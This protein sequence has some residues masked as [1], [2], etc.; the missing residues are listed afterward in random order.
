MLRWTPERDAVILQGIKEKWS[1]ALIAEKLG[2]GKEHRSSVT[3][4]VRR[5]GLHLTGGSGRPPGPPVPKLN[6]RTVRRSD[7]WRGAGRA[8]ATGAAPPYSPPPEPTAPDK[9]RAVNIF[10]LAAGMCRWPLWAYKERADPVTSL[11]CG[12]EVVPGLQYCAFHR[13]PVPVV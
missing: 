10:G 9:T 7:T 1:A 12:G 5:L 13:R 3:G 11:Y 4:R 2:I 8:A 6:P